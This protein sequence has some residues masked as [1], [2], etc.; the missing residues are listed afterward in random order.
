[1]HR[2]EALRILTAGSLLP[3][4]TPELFAFYRQAQPA[5][6]YAL[7]TLNAHSND[8]VVAMIDQI[9]PATDTPGARAARVNEFI[10]VILTEWANDEERRNFLSGLAGVDKQSNGL[11]SKDFVAASPEQQMTLLRSL[12]ESAKVGRSKSSSKERPPFWEPGGRDNQ[13]Q[14]DFFTVFKNLTLHG[15]YTS[16]IGFSQ[17]L[18]LQII[19]GEQHGCKPIGPGLGDADG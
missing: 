5:S 2:R 10:D 3:A 15:Y 1:M 11:F 7:R 18:K 6:G 9:I 19:P 16:E 8:T 14:D 12:D 13:L 4:L 17:E